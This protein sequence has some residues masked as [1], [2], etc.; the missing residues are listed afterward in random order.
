MEIQFLGAA[1]EV[2]RSAILLD[3]GQSKVLL[4][5]GLKLGGEEARSPV[6]PLPVHGFLDSVILSHAHMD[7]C[8]AIP[9]LFY[10]AEPRVYTTPA[11]I[12]LAEMLIRDSISISKNKNQETYNASSLKRML[13]NT[14]MVPYGQ[15]HKPTQDISFRFADAG[16]I[17]GASITELEAAGHRIVYT[18]DYKDEDTRMHK[19]AKP[20]KET[21]VLIIEATY[22]GR[23]HPPRK[24]IIHVSLDLD[25]LLTC[26]AGNDLVSDLFGN[27]FHSF[28]FPDYA[29]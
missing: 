12:P 7:H 9:Y 21:D 26:S 3:T 18:G 11:T 6:R 8:G 23:E 20:P 13:R 19:G 28:R 4:D 29:A 5:Y 10:A 15:V 24:K 17:L 2:G 25:D 27:G 16:H 14:K 1:R 22:G